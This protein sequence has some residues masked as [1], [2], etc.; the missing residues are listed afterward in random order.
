MASRRNGWQECFPPPKLF[1]LGRQMTWSW[2]YGPSDIHPLRRFHKKACFGHH[3][4]IDPFLTSQDNWPLFWHSW[5]LFDIT[6]IIYLFLTSSTVMDSKER[7]Q[8]Q[9]TYLPWCVE[10]AKRQLKNQYYKFYFKTF[11]SWV[12][13]SKNIISSF[14][15]H[16]FSKKSALVM[17]H[18]MINGV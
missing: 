2:P 5:P 7:I 3:K 13:L 12:F 9:M 11:A 16:C 4:I 18:W 15:A 1:I 8:N 14:M 17:Q 10:E 6:K